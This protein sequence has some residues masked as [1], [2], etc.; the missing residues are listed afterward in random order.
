ME[1]KKIL[2]AK[3]VQKVH[4][5]NKIIWNI[6]EVSFFVYLLWYVNETFTLMIVVV[7]EWMEFASERCYLGGYI[8]LRYT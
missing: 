7:V 8:L 2:T 3:I 5:I 4:K 6:S 1:K